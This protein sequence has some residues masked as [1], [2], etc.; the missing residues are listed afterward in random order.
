MNPYRI[1]IGGLQAW[2]Q[3]RMSMLPIN[4]NSYA[5]VPRIC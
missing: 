1:L 4:V 2:L 3:A 5:K